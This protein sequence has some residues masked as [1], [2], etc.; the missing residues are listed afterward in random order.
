MEYICDE[1]D[2]KTTPTVEGDPLR[3]IKACRCDMSGF[4]KQTVERYC[5]LAKVGI[6]TLKPVATPSIDDHQIKPEEI[7]PEEFEEP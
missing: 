4:N 5:E 1:D 6:N 3:S 7:K 2:P